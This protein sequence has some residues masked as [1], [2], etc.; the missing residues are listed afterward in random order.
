MI[1]TYLIIKSFESCCDFEKCHSSVYLLFKQGSS[2]F[3]NTHHWIL[4]SC[5][6]LKQTLCTLIIYIGNSLS[7]VCKTFTGIPWHHRIPSRTT[8]TQRRHKS[9]ISE[10]MG[11]CGSQNMLPQYLKIWEWE[12][13]FGRA[14]KA[15]SSLGVR[16]L[17]YRRIP[18]RFHIG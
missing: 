12:W 7:T 17:W 16:S 13:I 1:S 9:S 3:S 18:V 5:I 4:I 14:V 15:I 2:L 8:D 6:Y 11:R 10:K